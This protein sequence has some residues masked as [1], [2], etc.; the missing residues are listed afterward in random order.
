MQAL[1]G[2]IF[3]LTGSVA[4]GSF[5]MPYKKVRKWSWESYWIIGGIF[6]WLLAP[7]IFAWMTIPAFMNIIE[8]APSSVVN[9]VL[10]YGILWGIGGLTFGLGIR[11]L[12][13]SLGTSVI[14][15][16]SAAFGAI[17][18]T[19]YYDF[20]PQEGKITLTIML[21]E[22]WGQ[23]ILAGIGL[24]LLGIALCGKAGMMKEKEL[25]EK[26]KNKDNTE[27]NLRK[28]LTVAI[29]SGVLSAC[30]NFGIEAGKP[31]AERAVEIGSNPLYQNNAIFVLLLWGGFFTNF[32]WCCYLNFKNRS[33]Q[34]YTNLS[35]PLLK[36]YIF[37]AL[38]GLTWYMQFFFYGMGESKLGNG[39]S[40]WVLH[41]AAIILVGNL[42]GLFLK[43]WKGVKKKTKLTISLGIFTIL[44]AVFTVGYGN[45]LSS[46]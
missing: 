1:L 38:A 30:F 7:I 32:I 46:R 17:L 37:C 10:L 15:G 14:L 20:F 23:V 31:M 27:F 13:M 18:P 3:H 4:A 34:D 35:A 22:T 5:Y 21:T 28:G 45:F 26:E 19:I 24:S 36:N 12:G 16:F 6:S 25:N 44:L 29:V 41:M 43:E 11:Y 42:W 33:Y 8:E 40:S 9:Y 2:I 39:A